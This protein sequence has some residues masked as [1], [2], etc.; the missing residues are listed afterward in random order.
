MQFEMIY[1]HNSIDM[2]LSKYKQRS[3]SWKFHVHIT[4][5]IKMNSYK[6]NMMFAIFDW[7]HV[8]ISFI[9]TSLFF[10]RGYLIERSNRSWLTGFFLF[11]LYFLNKWLLSSISLAINWH[12]IRCL[13]RKQEALIKK[14]SLGEYKSFR[15]N[16]QSSSLYT[17]W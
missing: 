1:G 2:S 17:K 9:L 7:K 6:L 10:L 13:N 3:K 16:E 4:A 11:I 8:D 5:F 15:S 14:I 12:P